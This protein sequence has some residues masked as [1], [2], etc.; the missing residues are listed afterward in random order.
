MI[1]TQTPSET[2]SAQN[3]ETDAPVTPPVE[4]TPAEALPATAVVEE[5]APVEI[6]VDETVADETNYSHDSESETDEAAEPE[7]GFAALGLAC[8]AFPKIGAFSIH[9]ITDRW[10]KPLLALFFLPIL[11]QF[12]FEKR[13]SDVSSPPS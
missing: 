10:F 4:V 2:I 11:I 5:S 13:S 8:D 12:I 9:D 7:N 3:V 6:V 1:E